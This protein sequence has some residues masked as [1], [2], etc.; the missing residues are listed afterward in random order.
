MPAY[1]VARS[2]INDPVDYKKY[3]DL[4]PAIIEKFGGKILAR[5]GR[6]QIMEGPDKFPSVHRDR[7]SNLR[8]GRRL[9]HIAGIRP[10]AAF[11]RRGAGEVETIMVE[12]I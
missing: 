11:R 9:F 4:V 5:G 10:C 12:G 3:T 6:F 8:A 2:K 1:W 7:I